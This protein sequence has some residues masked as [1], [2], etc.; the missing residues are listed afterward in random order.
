MQNAL[1]ILLSATLQ[2]ERA[3]CGG[4]RVPEPTCERAAFRAT[5]RVLLPRC[6]DAVRISSLFILAL[7]T[8]HPQGLHPVPLIALRHSILY[9]SLCF[10]LLSTSFFNWCSPSSRLLSGS[11]PSILLDHPSDPFQSP[12]AFQAAS[13]RAALLPSSLFPSVLNY[14]C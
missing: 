4:S 1:L 5:T 11:K 6:H 9:Y 8:L 10:F 7:F 12:L 13:D 3:S 2:R 14:T